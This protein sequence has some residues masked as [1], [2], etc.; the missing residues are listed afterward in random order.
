MLPSEYIQKGWCRGAMARNN[1]GGNTL[2]HS[3]TAISWCALGG[4]SVATTQGY[5]NTE[6][7]HQMRE[8]LSFRVNNIGTWNDK[9]KSSGPIIAMLQAAEKAVL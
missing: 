5:I 9:Q 1:Q 3:H 6:Q 4:I 8:Y 2:G 7:A